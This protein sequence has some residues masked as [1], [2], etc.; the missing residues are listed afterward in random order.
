MVGDKPLSLAVT[1]S[2]SATRV[3]GFARKDGKAA[4]GVLVALI[5]KEP[6]KIASL[7]RRDQSDS[8]GSFGLLNVAP[9][10][11]TVLAI[12][13]GWNLDWSDPAVIGR[14]LPGGIA[15]TVKDSSDKRV[16]VSKAVPVQA[17]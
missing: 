2:A 15:V 10:D 8:D 4:A 9:G 7:S 16:Q 1:V 11:Y 3:E 14:Y 13:G 12:E 5:P 17:L 6:G